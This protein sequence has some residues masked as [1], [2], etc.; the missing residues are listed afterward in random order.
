MAEMF[1][2]QAR[3]KELIGNQRQI[4]SSLFRNKSLSLKKR[5]HKSQPL[6]GIPFKEK[7]VAGFGWLA[8]WNG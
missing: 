2:E 7:R 6:S 4:R 3:A 8:G 1:V 5:L